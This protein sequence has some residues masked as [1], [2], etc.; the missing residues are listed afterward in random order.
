LAW[1]L[2]SRAAG[3]A[4][5]A[6]AK[7]APEEQMLLRL[8][9]RLADK[10][11]A[12]ATA[13]PSNLE[14]RP[15]AMRTGAATHSEGAPKR[16]ALAPAKPAAPARTANAAPVWS[17]EGPTGP[18]AWAALRPEFARCGSGARQSPIDIRDGIAVDLEPVL[19]DYQAA[20]FRV[21][22]TGHTIEVG[23][24]QGNSIVA[25]GRRYELVQFHF[26]RPAEER[27]GGRGFEMGVHL[28]HRDEQGRLAVVAL[29]LEPG[30][31]NSVVQTVWNN[32]P[33]ERGEGVDTRSV[34]DLNHL[35]P[36]DRGYYTFMGSLTTPPCTEGVLWM[37]MRQPVAVSR[38][39]IEIFARLYPMNA[40]PLQA[41]GARMIK[42][43]N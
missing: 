15:A 18:R 17:Y 21:T 40:R 24:A 1:P 30:D 13:L 36:P 16:H 19:F 35:L 20:G 28:V 4:K 22:D 2:P 9:E 29:L 8:R 42:Q 14:P 11:G 37:V 3:E 43:S 6:Q 23:P 27:I 32:L 7:A 5:A 33:L 34:I 41:A 12:A 39:Q 10:L 38:E 26:H 31:G 25:Q